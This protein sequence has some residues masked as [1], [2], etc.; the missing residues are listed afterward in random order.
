[1]QRAFD[2][3]HNIKFRSDCHPN[4]STIASVGN[5]INEIVQYGL[6]DNHFETYPDRIRS[7]TIDKVAA[8]A[9]TVLHPENLIWIVVGDREKIAAGI[10]EFYHNLKKEVTGTKPSSKE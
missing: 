9:K 6:P 4:L 10:T 2:F 1:M 3:W 5:S 7:L 8:A